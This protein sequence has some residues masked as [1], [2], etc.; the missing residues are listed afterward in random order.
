MS[1]LGIGEA[2]ALYGEPAA[3]DMV[4]ARR[5]ELPD[6]LEVVES[7]GISTTSQ[8]CSVASGANDT[9]RFAMQKS[10][11]LPLD[12]E[13]DL[14]SDFRLASLR[15]S[16]SLRSRSF[17]AACCSSSVR[18]ATRLWSL[19]GVGIRDGDL[20]SARRALEGLGDA[21]DPFWG[22]RF[23]EDTSIRSPSPFRSGLCLRNFERGGIGF[24]GDKAIVGFK[25]DLYCG[26][27]AIYVLMSCQVHDNVDFTS[28][29]F[30]CYPSHLAA[31]QLLQAR[32]FYFALL[33]SPFLL[34]Y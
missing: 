26:V 23:G 7:S 32:Y 16:C 34:R 25:I 29:P 14:P 4:D 5:V 18:T 2:G 6:A 24:G 15:A 11:G 1:E 13:A 33:A 12:S 21:C 28:S 8:V 9:L 20:C 30:V 3:P 31:H 19:L 27:A 22:V 17:T 10:A